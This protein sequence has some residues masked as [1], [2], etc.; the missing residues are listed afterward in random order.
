VVGGQT[1]ADFYS[2]ELAR[3]ESFFD[4]VSERRVG[5]A[6][7]FEGSPSSPRYFAFVPRQP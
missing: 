6:R 1:G 3:D 2:F 7:G 5:P 4:M